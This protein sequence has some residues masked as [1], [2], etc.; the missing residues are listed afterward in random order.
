MNKIK[1][2]GLGATGMV[3]QRFVTLLADHSWFEIAALTASDN[4]AGKKYADACN[5]K[6]DVPMPENVCEMIVAPSTPDV[7]GRIAFSGLHASIA[8]DVELAFADAGFA[9]VTNA[10][11]HRMAADIP[12]LIPEINPHH[13]DIIPLQQQNRG[14]RK[15]F[16]V[17]NP[18]CVTVPMSMVLGPLHR[19]WGVDKVF[20]VTLQALSG[21]GYPGHSAL[22]MVDNVIPYIGGEESK[23]ETESLKI[24]GNLESNVFHNANFT[25]SAM[26]NRVAVID[27]HMLSLSVAFR[28]K[29]SVDEVIDALSRFT[30]EPQHLNLPSAPPKPIVVRNEKN[31]PQPRLDRN[32]GNG[33]AVVV[34]RVRECSLLDVKMSVLGHN[35]LRGAAGAAVLNAELLKAKGYID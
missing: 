21:A 7:D 31:R 3:G 5:W 14:W 11:N 27:G 24:L 35:T 9:V 17:T 10:R 13:I 8:G 18:N 33:M 12:L 1:V 6:Q 19:Q 32:T 28:Q 20:V 16:I 34:G 23:V 15:G 25:I 26:V 2:A 29:P 4:S 30:S 22:D